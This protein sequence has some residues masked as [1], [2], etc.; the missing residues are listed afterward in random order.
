MTIRDNELPDGLEAIIGRYGL[1]AVWQAHRQIWSMVRDWGNPLAI[2]AAYEHKARK[3]V[4]KANR[5]G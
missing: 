3:I 5:T 4:E 2:A 1:D